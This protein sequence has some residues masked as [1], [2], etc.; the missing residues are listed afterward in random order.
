MTLPAWREEAIGK[1]HDRTAFDCGDDVLNTY[2][3]RF[4]RQ[5][6]ES[7]GAKTFLALDDTGSR[8]LGYYSLAPTSASYEEVPAGVRRGLPRHPVPGFRLVRLATDRQVQGL[9]FGT[10]LLLAA[11]RRCLQVASEV[12]GVALFI[13]AKTERAALWYEGRGAIRLVTPTE[14]LPVPLV[15]PL[16]TLAAA[17]KTAGQLS[18][19]PIEER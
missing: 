13:D 15:I 10:Q 4:A 5:N 19:E 18:P 17:L 2:L 12:G 1:H 11:G 8:I 14:T 7:G 16:T 3:V 6:H 9:G